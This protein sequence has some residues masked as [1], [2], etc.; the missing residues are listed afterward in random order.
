MVPASMAAVLTVNETVNQ[1]NINAMTKLLNDGK[2]A[3]IQPRGRKNQGVSLPVTDKLK[4]RGL[5]IGDEVK[6]HLQDGDRVTANRQPTLHKHGWMAPKV[7][8]REGYM[9]LGAPL[10]QTTPYNLDFEI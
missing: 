8:V 9:T 7:K 4:R 5:R 6:R 10:P 1:Y 2:I 3:R